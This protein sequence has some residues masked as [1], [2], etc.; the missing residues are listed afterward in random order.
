MVRKISCKS[1]KFIIIVISTLK[2]IRKKI[3]MLQGKVNKNQYKDEREIVR[4]LVRPIQNWHRIHVNARDRERDC[5]TLTF[6]QIIGKRINNFPDVAFDVFVEAGLHT[7]GSDLVTEQNYKRFY[8]GAVAVLTDYE[9]ED[10]YKDIKKF[11]FLIRNHVEDYKDWN[12]DKLF[13]LYPFFNMILIQ[14]IL[15]YTKQMQFSELVTE[16]NLDK[17]IDTCDRLRSC[18]QP[19]K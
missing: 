18:N 10:K 3:I 5:M 1:K 4:M 15:Y 14:N 11:L 19:V 13:A 9:Q 6:D 17:L 2:L 16:A 12:F 8:N 7:D